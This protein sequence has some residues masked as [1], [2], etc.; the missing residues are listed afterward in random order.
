MNFNQQLYNKW[1]MQSLRLERFKNGAVKRLLPILAEID[2]QVY[3]LFVDAYD[4][5]KKDLLRFEKAIKE[6]KKGAYAKFE[7]EL[8]KEL[9]ELTPMQVAWVEGLF[10]SMLTSSIVNKA[11]PP[12]PHLIETRGVRVPQMIKDLELSDIKAI[13][14]TAKTAALDGLTMKEAVERTKLL[15]VKRARKMQAVI[16]TVVASVATQADEAVMKANTHLIKGMR[17]AVVFD[18]RT[19][20]ICIQHSEENKLYP[21]D[22]YPMPPFHYNCRT[23]PVP[24]VKDFSDF[25]S[26]YKRRVPVGKRA[27]MTGDTTQDK[28]YSQWLKNQPKEIQDDALGVTRAKQFRQGKYKITRFIDPTGKFYTVDELFGNDR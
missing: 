7:I 19:T 26:T 15:T 23:R 4:G 24:I 10:A 9:D 12:K 22:D 17:L 20:P 27:S 18:N 6:L 3:G 28:T 25:G 8:L 1:I 14:A 5:T 11:T 21:V 13:V 16:R 2:G